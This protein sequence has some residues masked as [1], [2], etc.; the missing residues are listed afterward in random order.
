MENTHVKILDNFFVTH[1]VKSFVLERPQNFHFAPGQATE[2]SINSE[3]WREEK[4]PFTMTSLKAD[5]FLQFIIKGYPDHQGV[6]DKLFKLKI[7][8]ELILHDVF[9][10]IQY[11][12]KGTFI[13]GGTGITPF[14]AILRNL[15]ANNEI[16]GNRLIFANK[17][18]RDIILKKEL[19]GLLDANFINIL[20]EEKTEKYAHG[21]ISKDF[22]EKQIADTNGMF[23]VC[24]PPPMMDAVL[25]HLP[26][27][28]VSE[29]S[30]IKEEM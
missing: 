15:R 28:G 20:S 7:G 29:K 19:E 3:E 11:H 5:K 8:D 6:T 14:I 4:R 25:E 30:I 10:D 13:A 2:I 26:A 16:D 24:G 17:T 1:D 18:S 21:L 22:L 23:Y 12:G 27:L 9:G